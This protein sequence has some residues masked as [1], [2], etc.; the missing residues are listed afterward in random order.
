[1]AKHFARLIA[2]LLFSVLLINQAFA[3]QSCDLNTNAKRI[4][5]TVK[6]DLLNRAPISVGGRIALAWSM[7]GSLP[8][9]VKAD[10]IMA[11]SGDVR[12]EGQWISEKDKDGQEKQQGPGFIPVSGEAR[13]AKTGS[14]G[15]GSARVIVPL[16]E[17]RG[18]SRWE[19]GVRPFVAGAFPITWA[20]ILQTPGCKNTLLREGTVGPVQ[21]EPGA[22]QPLVQDFFSLEEELRSAS[23]AEQPTSVFKSLSGRYRLHVYNGRYRVF[24]DASG[25]KLIDRAGWNVNFS[26]TSRFVA[27]TMGDNRQA[28]PTIEI[29]DLISGDVV[30]TVTGPVIAWSHGD[31][32]LITGQNHYG[33]SY[34]TPVL[35]NTSELALDRSGV[36]AQD[37]Y[38]GTGC[39]T[40]T[41]WNSDI[42]VSLADGVGLG[43]GN[44]SR[45]VS[46]SWAIEE[47]VTDDLDVGMRKFSGKADFKMRRGWWTDDVIRLSHMSIDCQKSFEECRNPVKQATLLVNH[48]RITPTTANRTASKAPAEPSA[49]RSLW[50]M[51]RGDNPST[52]GFWSRLN[53][54]VIP[55]GATFEPSKRVASLIPVDAAKGFGG[56]NRAFPAALRQRIAASDKRLAN[57]DRPCGGSGTSEC[58]LT[59][60]AWDLSSVGLSGWLVQ[61]GQI[62]PTWTG[63]QEPGL[64]LLRDGRISPLTEIDGRTSQFW[65]A[66]TYLPYVGVSRGRYLVLAHKGLAQAVVVDFQN[67]SRTR[68]PK[69]RQAELLEE[70]ALSED[71]RLL[72]QFNVD[73]QFFVY[74]RDTGTPLLSG[75]FIDDEVVIYDE[76]AT[77][78]ATYE[79]AHFVYLRFPGERGAFTFH[80][81]AAALDNR[82]VI[83]RVLTSARTTS[84]N[85]PRLAPPPSI[86][87]QPQSAAKGFNIEARSTTGLAKI[88]IFVDGRPHQELEATGQQFKGSVMVDGLGSERTLAAVAV[89]RSGFVS[90]T[91]S[92]RIETQ[93]PPAARL[94]SV[95]VGINAYDDPTIT[96]LRY[97]RSD[98]ESLVKAVQANRGRYYASVE[99]SLLVDQKA[100]ADAIV[101]ALRQAVAKANPADTLMFYF[102]GHGVQV[103]E[104]YFLTTS[105]T[106]LR[107]IPRT[108]LSWAR[109]AAALSDSKARTLVILDSCHSGS[110][111]AE[112]LSSN[113]SAVKGLLTGDRRPL[114]VLAASKG[115]QVSLEEEKIGG[116]FTH[117]IA[118]VIS[119]NRSKYDTNSNGII[120]LSELYAGVKSEVSRRSAGAQTPWLARMDP[121]GDF[122]LF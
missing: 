100:S 55:L 31:S 54:L 101:D 40:C 20:I 25:V 118:D 116:Y 94:I 113:D 61:T 53:E 30:R 74:A 114:I 73:G 45:L 110:S 51:R 58:D 106:L 37:I 26:P 42:Y 75:R 109:V 103:P 7:R 41:G 108:S 72:L 70:L 28:I 4:L 66:N 49:S 33:G 14:F 87:I 6:V 95:V 96:Q 27:A 47:D 68:V 79:G 105:Q 65:N 52:I 91:A 121:I 48:P 69:L 1:M 19:F 80:Q 15:D 38:L 63:M 88:R 89:D 5:E 43:N 67:G 62:N 115:R 22:P 29:I 39:N 18:I 117:A 82:D 36:F 17:M 119:S 24:D 97:A 122:S 57:F 12:F 59:Y 77:Y 11:M 10:L 34:V 76:H 56:F 78:H 111:G 2:P 107:D 99:Q 93:G 13:V 60:G 98:A 104:G 32:L 120:E 3:Q 92:A 84:Y 46:L 21:I 8:A 9:G 64:K 44:L 85:V 83:G 16:H 86:V 81:F 23:P 35:L 71:A 90:Q 50:R 102:A 112:L